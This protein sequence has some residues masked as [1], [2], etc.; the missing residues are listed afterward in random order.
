MTYI[1]STIHDL[2]YIQNK[3]ISLQNIELGYAEINTQIAILI[4]L[5]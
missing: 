2:C 5:H 4:I 3:F 1:G